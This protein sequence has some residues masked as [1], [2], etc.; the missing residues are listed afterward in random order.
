LILR[1]QSSKGWLEMAFVD[2]YFPWMKFDL[3][4]GLE[5]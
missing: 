4:N 2:F 5:T 3:L 1:P